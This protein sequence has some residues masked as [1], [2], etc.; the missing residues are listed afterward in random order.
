MPLTRR[1]AVPLAALALV[2]GASRAALA[3]CSVTRACSAAPFLAPSSGCCGATTCTIDGTVTLSGPACGLDFGARNVTLSG[4]LVVGSGTLTLAAGGLTVTGLLNARGTTAKPGG[5]VTLALGAGGLSLARGS[6]TA[7]DLEG[8]A[9]GGGTLTAVVGGRVSLSG[10]DIDASA[11][12][13][14]ASGGTITLQQT[15]GS[16]PMTVGISIRANAGTDGIGGTITLQAPADL[17]AD[18]TV[19]DTGS[20]VAAGGYVDGGSIELDAEGG[21]VTVAGAAVIRA[22]GVSDSGGDGGDISIT[23]GSVELD[24]TLDA[25]GGSDPTRDT[26]GQ[27]GTIEI[28]AR[29]GALTLMQGG[30]GLMADGAAGNDGGEVD[31]TTDSP[32]HG[33]LTVAGPVSAH[34]SGGLAGRPGGGGTIDIESAHALT[35]TQRL[36]VTGIGGGSGVA[37]LAAQRDVMINASIDGRDAVGFGEVDVTAGHDLTFTGGNNLRVNA[38]LDGPGGS[39]TALAGNDLTLTGF[40]LDASGAGT[41]AGTLISLG[42]EHN[43]SIDRTST[44]NAKS[45]Q[46]SGAPGGNIRL[47]AGSAGLAGNLQ[48][49]GPVTATGPASTSAPPNPASIFLSGC[50]VTIS[51]TGQVDSSGDSNARNLVIGRTGITISGNLK[52]TAA[53]AGGRNTANYPVG[54]TPTVSGSNA[55]VPPFGP[56]AGGCAKPVCT[57]RGTP[58]GCLVPSPACGN[59]AVEFPEQCDPPG[60]PTCDLDGQPL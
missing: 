54:T 12:E 38:T 29:T 7:I 26:G 34:G 25:G 47:T 20:I 55:V 56:C 39:I 52:T 9:A 41:G 50:Q 31:L 58:A 5:N 28:E 51:G 17:N 46:G 35:L 10:G 59:G 40:L 44:L 30:Q 16:T 48:V 45:A 36:D 22:K 57:A 21:K 60:S 6:G 33:A 19:T 32:A 53:A 14:E 3:V 37:T 13:T 1:L 15:A 4:A 23:A 8:F 24:G 27:G 2:L 11:L 43:L 18:L 49:A 42:A